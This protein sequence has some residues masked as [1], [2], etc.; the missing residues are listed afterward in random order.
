MTLF[1]EIADDDLFAQVLEKCF[2]GKED[3]KTLELLDKVFPH[4]K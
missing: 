4:D 2:E 1:N 3:N